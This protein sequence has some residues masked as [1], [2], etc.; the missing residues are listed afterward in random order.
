MVRPDVQAI[1]AAVA[2]AGDVHC[3]LRPRRTPAVTDAEDL[4]RPRDYAL[5]HQLESLREQERRGYSTPGQQRRI[6]Q[7]ERRLRAEQHAAEVRERQEH[8]RERHDREERSRRHD[9]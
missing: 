6:E 1:T 3:D 8:D 4:P 5:E 9:R 2:Q 7:L